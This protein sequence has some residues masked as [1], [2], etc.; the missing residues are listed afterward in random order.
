MMN[1]YPE[2]AD[3]VIIACSNAMNTA[4]AMEGET[5]DSLTRISLVQLSLL[6]E[7]ENA[8]IFKFD[9]RSVCMLLIGSMLGVNLMLSLF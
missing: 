8:R 1:V 7:D 5:F 9:K 2:N 4:A 6:I 3:L